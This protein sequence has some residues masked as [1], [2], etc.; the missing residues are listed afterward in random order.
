MRRVRLLPIPAVLLIAA[1]SSTEESHGP[2]PLLTALPRALSATETR[3]VSAGNQFGF[4]LL[5]HA[6]QTAPDG[7]LFLSPLSVSMALGMALNGAGGSTADSMRVALGMTGQSIGEINQGYRNLIDLLRGLDASSQF[8]IANSIWARSGITFLPPFLTAGR[9]S[10]D[11]EI[12]ALDFSA[13]G[14]LGTINDWVRANTNGKIPR[15]LDDIAPQ[16]VMFLINAI[17][18]K[19]SWRLAF[20]PARTTSAPFNAGDG[21]IQSVRTMSQ[22]P[23]VQRYSATRDFE[24]VELLYGNGAFAMTIVLP[25]A[26]RTLS[27]VTDGLDADRWGEWVADLHDREIGLAMPRFTLE[28]TRDLSDDLKALGMRVAFDP[29]AAD[30]TAMADVAPDRLY[31]TRVAHKTF[32]DVNEEGTEAAAATSV[33]V[34]VTSAPQTMQIDRPFLFVIR[35]R[36]TGAILFLGQLTRVP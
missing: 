5:R 30:F 32:V 1:C 23:E 24:M 3:M 18:F 25:R 13:P 4:D 36:L 10:F 12:R 16:E 35:E 27:D 6:R 19:G 22:R 28:Y 26:D 11:A 9:T 8:Q 33:G 14:T 21:S 20:D 2:P 29:Q 15:I 34:G 17:Y 7:N 31:L